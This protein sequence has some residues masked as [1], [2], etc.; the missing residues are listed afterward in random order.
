MTATL[1]GFVAAFAAG[2]LLL[3]ITAAIDAD[4][5]RTVPDAYGR[6]AGHDIHPCWA[7]YDPQVLREAAALVAVEMAAVRAEMHPLHIGHRELVAA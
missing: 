4:D 1:I 2:L 6:G 7:E 5:T 3:Y